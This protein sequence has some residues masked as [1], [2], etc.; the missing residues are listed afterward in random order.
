MKI[1]QRTEFM[2]PEICGQVF[3]HTLIHVTLNGVSVRH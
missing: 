3:S 2:F 1:G